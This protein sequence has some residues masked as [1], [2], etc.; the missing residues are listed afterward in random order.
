MLTNDFTCGNLVGRNFRQAK[1]CVGRN[2]RHLS[3]NSLLSPDKILLDKVQIQLLICSG[4]YHRIEPYPSLQELVK[5]HL[6]AMSEIST[7]EGVFSYEIE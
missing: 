1:L 5:L 4:M 3:K 7:L 2:F 6:E